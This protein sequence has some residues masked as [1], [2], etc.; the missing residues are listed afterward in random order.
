MEARTSTAEGEVE[1]AEEKPWAENSVE[2]QSAGE[3]KPIEE[4]FCRGSVAEEYQNIK[5]KEKVRLSGYQEYQ[6]IRISGS[7]DIYSAWD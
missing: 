1:P 7:G 6:Q 3:G 4:G 5:I 2:V